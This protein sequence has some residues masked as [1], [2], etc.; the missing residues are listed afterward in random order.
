MPSDTSYYGCSSCSINI[1]ENESVVA[2]VLSA[3]NQGLSSELNGDNS[4]DNS[5]SSSS[6]SSS[7]KSSG[8]RSSNSNSS[9]SSS[10]NR[11]TK[12][13][14][15]LVA[16]RSFD[17][18]K[19]RGISCP[20]LTEA[21]QKVLSLGLSNLI[22]SICFPLWLLF[23]LVTFLF[24]YIHGSHSLFLVLAHDFFPC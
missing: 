12:S 10:D 18:W 15:T 6:S 2:E 20:G 1:E 13:Q 23:S 4:G 22:L 17:G 19:R 24:D 3:V 16:P 7:K 21:Q 14:W 5:S 11:P 9:S 8:S